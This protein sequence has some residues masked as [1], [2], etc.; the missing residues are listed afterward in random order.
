MTPDPG[1]GG[2]RAGRPSPDRLSPGRPSPGRSAFRR[3]LPRDRQQALARG[4]L[5]ETLAV[6]LLRL[7]GYRILARDLR[8]PVGEV[9]VIARRGRTLV[10]VEVKRRAD[11][12]LAL[13][14][15]GAR[16]RRRIERASDAFVAGRPALAALDRRFDLVLVAA[17]RLPHH[18]ADAW[19]P[20]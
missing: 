3:P 1:P 16:Q 13:E 11:R 18:V 8:L 15:V 6:W 19:R 5:A 20:D 9:D 17:G 10:F 7:K 14:S 12:E 2:N 4:R